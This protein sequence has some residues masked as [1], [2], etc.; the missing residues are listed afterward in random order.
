MAK[1]K[2]AA[3]K[4]SVPKAL[5]KA[6]RAAV[7]PPKKARAKKHV[8]FFGAGKADGDR[9]MKDVLGGKGSG[10]AEMTNAGLPVPP[11]F[12]IS[13]GVCNIY[14]AEK[15]PHPSRDRSRDRRQPAQARKGR[16]QEARR[17]V[18]PAARVG[19]VGREVLDAGHDGHDPEPRAERPDGRGAL[20]QDRQPA[21][22][23]RQLPPLHPDVRQRRARH[24]EGQVRARV[25]GGEAG[26][27]RRDRHRS[28]RRRPARGRAPLQGSGHAR[29]RQA[30]PAG[31]AAAAARLARRG[32]QVV[33][34]PAREGLPPHLRDPR[35]HRHRGQRAGN[36]VRQ[37]R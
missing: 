37:H 30:V 17:R 32:V 34:E 14:Y 19:P 25:R 33:D 1:A 26:A 8:F 7:A 29:G 24:L 28:R 27:R 5:V 21:V 16:G 23:L 3:K 10:L 15:G 13:T 20:R 31:S 12:T 6:V 11:G 22:R 2:T 9:T 35:S 4:A 36:G 18:E